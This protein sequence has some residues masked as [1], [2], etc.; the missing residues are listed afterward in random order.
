M[1]QETVQEL[2]AAN[3]DVAELLGLIVA[4]AEGDLAVVEGFEPTI[5][6]GDA[7]DVTRQVT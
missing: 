1:L 3:A 2:F 4:I 7:Q 6:D 5:G